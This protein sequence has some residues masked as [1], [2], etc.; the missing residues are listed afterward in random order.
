MISRVNE[1]RVNARLDAVFGALSDPIRRTIVARLTQGECSVT[2]LS[3][4]FDVSAPA[5]TK[6]LHVLESS[7]LITRRK[8]GRVNYCT[9]NEVSLREAD[10]WIKEQRRFWEQQLNA[11]DKYLKKEKGVCGSSSRSG[12]DEPSGSDDYSRRRKK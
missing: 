8:E 9:L 11:L 5:I 3:E 12:R 4:P 1:R 10:D 6:H 7:G 2:A